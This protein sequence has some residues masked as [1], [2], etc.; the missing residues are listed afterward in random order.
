MVEHAA[1]VPVLA[2]EKPDPAD[3]MPAPVKDPAA[4][5][6]HCVRAIGAMLNLAYPLCG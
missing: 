6:E 4:L 1:P 2:H 5:P 3:D